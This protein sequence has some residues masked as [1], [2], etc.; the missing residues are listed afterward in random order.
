MWKNFSNRFH[1][2]RAMLDYCMKTLDASNQRS[3]CKH[4]EIDRLQAE[5]RVLLAQLKTTLDTKFDRRSGRH[6]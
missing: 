6:L 1:Q 4:A 5:T 3:E 2:F